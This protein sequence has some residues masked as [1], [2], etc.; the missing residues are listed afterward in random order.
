MAAPS[1]TIDTTPRDACDAR[2][3]RRRA[4]AAAFALGLCT[5]AGALAGAWAWLPER[6]G[7]DVPAPAAAL[8]H[9]LPVDRDRDG[10]LDEQ[11]ACPTSPRG[12]SVDDAGC[13]AFAEEARTLDFA[14]GSAW[15]SPASERRLARALRTLERFPTKRFEVRALAIVTD[16]DEAAISMAFLRAERVVDWFAARGV[17]SERVDVIAVA[18]VADAAASGVGPH[19]ELVLLR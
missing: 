7:A 12:V 9:S 14:A 2:G 19:V 8:P 5:G 1:Q 3:G 15:L 11:D 4:G 10:L 13:T 17:G 6:G 16:A 18:R